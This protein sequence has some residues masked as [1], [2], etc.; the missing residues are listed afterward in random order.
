MRSG[1]IAAR[2]LRPDDTAARSGPESCHPRAGS[3]GTRAI[4]DAGCAKIGAAHEQ[5]TAFP[6]GHPAAEG[7]APAAT[8]ERDYGFVLLNQFTLGYPPGAIG[9]E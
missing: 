1:P 9:R 2:G 3:P 5:V 6:L 8:A 4:E 7:Y